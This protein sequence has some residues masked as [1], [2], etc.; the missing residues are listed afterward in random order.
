[1]DTSLWK[2]DDSSTGIERFRTL[3]RMETGRFAAGGFWPA[4]AGGL[5]IAVSYSSSSSNMLRA[6]FL[7]RPDGAMIP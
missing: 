4:L 3:R 2:S 5:C 1:M 7:A 6:K